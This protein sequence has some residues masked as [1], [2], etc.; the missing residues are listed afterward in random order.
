MPNQLSNTFTYAIAWG[1]RLVGFNALRLKGIVPE[2]A[3]L[4]A[5]VVIEQNGFV[6]HS[7][8]YLEASR[9][10]EWYLYIVEGDDYFFRI[11]VFHPEHS[12]NM[13]VHDYLGLM[14]S[15]E[16]LVIDG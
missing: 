4:M 6:P 5:G 11:T 15:C 3:R 12:T 16:G 9:K 7:H 14:L 2:V 1:G 10:G 13:N 8:F